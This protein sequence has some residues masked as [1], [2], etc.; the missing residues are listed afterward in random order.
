MINIQNISKFYGPLA[1][2]KNVSLTLQEGKTH[3]LLGSSGSGKSTLLR[4]ISGLIDVDAGVV[5][6]DQEIASSKNQKKLS[7]QIAYVIQEGGLFPHLTARENI[8]LAAK[9]AGWSKDKIKKRISEL[10]QLVLLNENF[11]EQYPKQLSGGQRQRIA[12]MRALMLDP[13]IIL[14]DE[15]LGALDPLVRSELQREL[16]RIFN[17]V[18]KT[19]VMVTHDIGEAAFFGHTLS[20]F[21]EGE[22]IQ[23]GEL[24]SFMK[25]PA[26]EFVTRFFK[27]QAPPQELLESL[28]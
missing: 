14:L 15:P 27:A 23:H 2:L 19:V 12:L 1:A 7:S 17:L 10:C 16:K 9:L 20:L 11:I 8:A 22:L 5:K 28:L 21:H 3:I 13:P 24:K 18:Q 26:N 4:I 25:N 6:I